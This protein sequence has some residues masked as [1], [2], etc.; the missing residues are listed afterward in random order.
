MQLTQEMFEAIFP[1]GVFEYFDITACE[2][3]KNEVHFVFTEKDLPPLLPEHK[4]KKILRSKLHPITITDYPLRGKKTLLTF[5]RR[6]WKLDGVQ[7]YLK[8]DIQLNFPGTQL[9]REFA[10]F[11]KGGSRESTAF[12]SVYCH[13]Q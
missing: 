10:L 11:L 2:I 3:Q 5:K 7:K 4:G 6:Y 1:K 9:E 13:R 12:A 8:R